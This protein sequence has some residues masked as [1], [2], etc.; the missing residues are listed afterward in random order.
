MQPSVFN[1]KKIRSE[2]YLRYQ[3]DLDETSSSILFILQQEQR[4]N[5]LKQN[6]H[7]E[8]ATRKIDAAKRSLQV[9]TQNPTLQAF[10]FGMGKWGM[11]LIIAI[12][13]TSIFYL[14][15]SSGEEPATKP[16]ELLQWY[17][18]YYQVSQRESKK[19]VTDFLKKY[20]MPQH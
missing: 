15:H 3:V 19:M 8:E 6:Q 9:D 20:P 13:F 16:S 17:Q 14:F 2:L 7:L 11:A 1:Y 12:A 18:A 10:W 4:E 5:F